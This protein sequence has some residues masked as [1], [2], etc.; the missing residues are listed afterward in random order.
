MLADLRRSR[1]QLY[2]IGAGFQVLPR[3]E[4]IQWRLNQRRTPL[5]CPQCG[6]LIVLRIRQASR[7]ENQGYRKA[8]AGIAAPCLCIGTTEISGLVSPGPAV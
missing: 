5:Q 4:R 8:C 7:G 3:I 2:A 6:F 1:G